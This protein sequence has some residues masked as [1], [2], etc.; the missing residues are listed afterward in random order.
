MRTKCR[1]IT[2]HRPIHSHWSLPLRQGFN[3]S[4]WF[5]MPL[6]LCL[7]GD[8]LFC[9][10][11]CERKS[12]QFLWCCVSQ[13][14][15]P[16]LFGVDV[17]INFNI[18]LKFSCWQLGTR[19]PILCLFYEGQWLE[20]LTPLNGTL[21]FWPLFWTVMHWLGCMFYVRID[22]GVPRLLYIT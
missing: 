2:F 1:S 16:E 15:K 18:F 6:N 12:L 17:F 7:N 9:F 4:V 21:A 19:T 8:N 20:G 14:Q 5:V 22:T 11:C 3:F 10:V 13:N